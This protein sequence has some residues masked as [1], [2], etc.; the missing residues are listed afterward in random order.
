[1]TIDNS[2]SF[3]YKAALVEKTANAAGG[4]SFVK[5]TKIVVL[6]KYL[7]NFWRSLKMPLINCKIHLE[8]NLIEDCILSIAGNSAKFKI[9]DAKL[10]VPIITLSGKDNVN[11]TKL[12]SNGFKISV[13]WNSYQTIPAKVIN[14]GTNIY[15]LP[16]ASF[17]GGKRLFVF[18]YDTVAYAANNE[19]AIKKVES[20]FFQ[21]KRS[22]IIMY[23]LMEEIFMIKQL[24]I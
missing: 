14:K 3:K 9:T 6:L 5:N 11:L 10:H 4:N 15:E 23:W 20:I 18:V 12:L 24:V 7:S 1:M 22:K 19:A 21:E 16:S 8:L 13:Y 2:Q 17:Q